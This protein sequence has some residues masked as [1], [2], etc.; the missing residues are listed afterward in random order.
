MN[1]FKAYDVRG[2]Y[3]IEINEKIVYN[4]SRAFREFLGGKN[5]LV[6]RDVRISSSR[7]HKALL[8]GLID[9]GVRV[10]DIGLSTTPMFYFAIKKLRTY[11]GIMITA[12]H[13]PKNYNGLKL[14][15][16]NSIP[17]SFGNGLEKIEKIFKNQNFKKYKKGSITNYNIL[18]KYKKFLLKGCV[19]TEL[20]VVVD[21]GNMVGVIDGKILE[22]VCNVK[23]LFFKIDGNIPNR[24]VDPSINKNTIKLS[25]TVLKQKA[26][27]GIAFDADSDRVVFLD[28]LGNKLQAH[29]VAWIFMDYIKNSKLVYDLTVSSIISKKAVQ[30]NIKP[31]ISKVGRT[32]IIRNMIKNKAVFGVESSGHYYYK[33]NNYLDSAVITALIMLKILHKKNMKLSDILKEIPETNIETIKIKSSKNL[34]NKFLKGSKKVLKIDGTSILHDDYW[35]NIRKSNTENISKV[36]IESRNKKIFNKIKAIVKN[37]L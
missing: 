8:S 12:S 22:G 5:I 17:I 18:N 11:G 3:P 27:L 6:A 4:I 33:K 36:T 37:N 13:L 25:Q 32:N 1:I 34:E 28:D 31:I 26:D 20:N 19:K 14:C 30:N 29:H 7:L 10:I 2:V 35:V 23:P 24:G 15:G 21:S 9:S 16:K